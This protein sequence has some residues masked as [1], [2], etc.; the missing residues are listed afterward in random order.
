VKQVMKLDIFHTFHH[1]FQYLFLLYFYFS[2]NSFIAQSLLISLIR[3]D[4]SMIY[5]NQLEILH[6][7]L[8][9]FYKYLYKDTYLLIRIYSLYNIRIYLLH[10]MLLI[11]LVLKV[12]IQLL[13]LNFELVISLQIFSQF[14]FYQHLE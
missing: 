14:L 4:D 12:D 11:L 10:L 13:F 8:S 6:S 7:F 2:F 9:T 3:N 1:P 5:L